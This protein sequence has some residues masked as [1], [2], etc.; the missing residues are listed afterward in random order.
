MTK[1]DLKSLYTPLF[2]IVISKKVFDDRK[3]L[4]LWLTLH[5]KKEK[6]NGSQHGRIADSYDI[7]DVEERVWK[8]KVYIMARVVISWFIIELYSLQRG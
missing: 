6:E 4:P 8:S 5:L 7:N 1:W 2:T 3:L